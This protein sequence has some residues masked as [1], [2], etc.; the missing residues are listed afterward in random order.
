MSLFALLLSAAI[1][2]LTQRTTRE[3]VKFAAISFALFVGIGV[4]VAWLL[5]PFSK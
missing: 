1:A 3:R 5:F 4:A 2:G